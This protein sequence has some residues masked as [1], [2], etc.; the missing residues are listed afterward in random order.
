MGWIK[1]TMTIFKEI[2]AEAYSGLIYAVQFNLRYV[3]NLVQLGIPYSMYFLGQMAATDRSVTSF[4]F[5]MLT[6]IVATIVV[7]YTKEVSNKVNRGSSIPVPNERFTELG[8][9]G[10]VTVEAERTQELLLYVADLEDWMARKG[11]L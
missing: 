10:E 7:F 4:A 3:A 6:P 8:E 9:D 2:T 5:D 11:W 1:K